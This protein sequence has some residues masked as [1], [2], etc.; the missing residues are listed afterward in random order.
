MSGPTG[1]GKTM[2]ARTMPTILSEMWVQEAL[3]VTRIYS[4]RGLLPIDVPSFASDPFA[5]PTMGPA[6]PG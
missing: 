3:E 4:V 1:S 2:L 5:R 6:R